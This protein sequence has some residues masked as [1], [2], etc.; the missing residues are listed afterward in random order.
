[1]ATH[2]RD[3]EGKP[4]I[5][6]ATTAEQSAQYC[7][8]AAAGFLDMG[9]RCARER[10]GIFGADGHPGVRRSC[11]S[12]AKGFEIAILHMIPE[13]EWQPIDDQCGSATGR[14]TRNTMVQDAAPGIPGGAQRFAVGDAEQLLQL[15][16]LD[17]IIR[18]VPRR[19][20]IPELTAMWAV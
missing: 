8:K 20:R 19:Q 17:P 12:P 6:S 13:K 16:K 11:E 4:F 10:V 3:I 7:R 18:I 2:S 14:G 1:M 5:L 15:G 9:L